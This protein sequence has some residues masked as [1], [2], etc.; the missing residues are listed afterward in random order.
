MVSEK[1]MLEAL[2]FGY[3]SLIPTLEIQEELVGLMGRP[4]REIAP[5]EDE[6]CARIKAA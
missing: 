2:M 4:K 5:A 1:E 6:A 3:E